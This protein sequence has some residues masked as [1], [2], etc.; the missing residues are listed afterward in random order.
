MTFKQVV[1]ESLLRPVQIMVLDPAITF[2]AIYTSLVY[3]IYYSFFEAFPLV[4]PVIY[5][6]NMGENGLVFLSVVV[7]MLLSGL[8]YCS[9]IWKVVRPAIK[10]GTLGPPEG[11]LAPALF[12]SFL[13]PIG[14]FYLV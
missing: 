14:L 10:A 8:V 7:G 2:A 11:A 6:F 3:S 12:A 1:V 13:P 4:Y 9:M 5:G